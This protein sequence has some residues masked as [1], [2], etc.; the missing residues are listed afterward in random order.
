MLLL[1]PFTEG[2]TWGP[3][4]SRQGRAR[5]SAAGLHDMSCFW[6]TFWHTEDSP[7]LGGEGTVI[8]LEVML[9]L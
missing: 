3:G 1:G 2:G 9:I 8:G 7:F 6:H 5:P 4:R